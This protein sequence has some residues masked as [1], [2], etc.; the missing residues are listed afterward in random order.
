MNVTIVTAGI[1]VNGSKLLIAQ[2]REKGSQKFKWEFPGGKLEENEKP[3]HGLKREIQEELGVLIEVGDIFE[4][5]YHRYEEIT[6]LLLCYK[7]RY[8]SGE[9]KAMECKDFNWINL[10]EIN[11]FDFSEADK[12]VREKLLKIGLPKF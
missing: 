5:V 4:V 10:D 8:I 12:E 9:A 7:A 2:R 11:Q 3:E 1:I 6:I